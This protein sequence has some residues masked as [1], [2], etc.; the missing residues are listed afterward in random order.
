MSFKIVWACSYKAKINRYRTFQ[1]V[2]DADQNE[3]HIVV[4][5]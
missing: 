5:A 4:Q 2:I 1:R 3:D